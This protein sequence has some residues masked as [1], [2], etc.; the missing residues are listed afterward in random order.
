MNK[1]IMHWSMTANEPNLLLPFIIT[2]ANPL[3][4]TG[5]TNLY[6]HNQSLV[7]IMTGIITCTQTKE[8]EYLLLMDILFWSS[9]LKCL[10]AM[11]LIKLYQIFKCASVLVDV[12]FTLWNQQKIAKSQAW[13]I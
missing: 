4:P 12:P 1:E 10:I 6:K 2:Q 13:D 5:S 8:S 7:D 3:T 11:T 9:I